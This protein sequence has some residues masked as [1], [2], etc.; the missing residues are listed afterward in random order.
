MV[1]WSDA[2]RDLIVKKRDKR[3]VK[4][5]VLI[6]KAVKEI[7][8]MQEADIVSQ[9]KDEKSVQ[10]P[11]LNFKKY[12]AVWSMKLKP[13]YMKLVEQEGNVALSDVWVTTWFQVWSPEVAK[14]IK[15]NIYLLSSSVDDTTKKKL[16][17]ILEESINEWI[18]AS[19][20]RDRI[21]AEFNTMRTSRAEAI[22]RTE[23]IR[24]S[25]EATV[26]WW[27]Q[28]WVVSGKEWL[29][30]RD[31]RVSEICA[32]LD[33][34]IISLNDNFFDKWDKLTVGNNTYTLDYSDTSW[35]PSHVNCRC[36]LIP[37][38]KQ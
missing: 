20:V 38:I 1:K 26:E 10:L 27:N 17:K 5:E 22:W 6:A 37:V 28:S 23:T 4:Y 3:L 34:K 24:M 12:I 18:G 14:R 31:D 35:P 9:I 7:A 11:E 21:S 30:A 36:T 16:S 8:D 33:G 15:E 25:N 29:T 32:S 2:N 19:E 13:V